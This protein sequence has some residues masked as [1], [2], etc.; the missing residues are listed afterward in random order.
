MVLGLPMLTCYLSRTLSKAQY[1]LGLNSTR[2]MRWRRQPID[3]LAG[4]DLFHNRN[5]SGISLLPLPD[6]LRSDCYG[7]Y[8]DCATSA[9]ER[10]YRV[11]RT[12][13]REGVVT[14]SGYPSV[15]KEYSIA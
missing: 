10:G 12:P 15:V 9:V 8:H 14:A 7:L 5:G 2:V 6:D 13:G 11:L 4:H 1:F 3:Q